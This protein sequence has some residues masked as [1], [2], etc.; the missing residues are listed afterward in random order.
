[1]SKDAHPL[2]IFMAAAGLALGPAPASAQLSMRGSEWVRLRSAARLILGW[3][4]GVSPGSFQKATFFEAV[5]QVASPLFLRVIEGAS[6]QKVSAE[7]PKN[8]DYALSESEVQAVKRKLAAA[9]VQMVAYSLG[10]IGPD[11]T[12]ARKAFEFARSLDVEILV[13]GPGV[14]ARAVKV[15]DKLGNES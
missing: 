7:I 11:E 3:R 10:S 5:D 8:L 15:L 1:M 2:L 9:G 12:A 4:V 6:T 13:A 14:D